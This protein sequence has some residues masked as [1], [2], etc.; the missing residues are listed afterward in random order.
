[1]GY[2]QRI[3][4]RHFLTFGLGCS[5]LSLACF[6][7]NAGVQGDDTTTG[8]SS[9][10]SSQTDAVG[11]QTSQ[12]GGSTSTVTPASSSTATVG[13]SPTTDGTTVGLDA[14]SEGGGVCGDGVV[15][16]GEACD[17]GRS[18]GPGSP[19]TENCSSNE[20][21]D[22]LVAGE[23]ACDEGE[24]NGRGDGDCAP[25]CSTVVSTKV[26][27]L[28]ILNSTNMDGD[29][30]GGDAPSVLDQGCV[31][32][33][34]AGYRAMFADGVARRAS[35]T[36]NVGDGQIDWVLAPWTRYV[37]SLGAVVWTTDETALLG[38]DGGAIVALEAPIDTTGGL[39]PGAVV[40]GMAENWVAHDG[41][42]CNES[43]SASPTNFRATA[44]P[45][46]TL[47]G[48]YL[49]DNAGAVNCSIALKYYC[50]EQ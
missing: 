49:D 43:S 34:L 7:P 16:P 35:S 9:T 31:D 48:A 39:G 25:D 12:T 3:L 2:A 14:S 38:V 21:G 47:N 13:S 42:M 28:N 26:I 41:N 32:S 44:D 19:C 33:G 29:M 46:A 40:T 18:N 1:M 27:R 6:A 36:P 10:S 50:V 45:S 23:E 4:H 5:C 37:N 17:E 24:E 11:A 30:G 20:C 15:D 8:T 22:G